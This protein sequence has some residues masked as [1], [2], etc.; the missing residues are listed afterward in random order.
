VIVRHIGPPLARTGGPSGYLLELRNA[1]TAS[2]HVS[3]HEI[4]FPPRAA[5]PH[6][7]EAWAWKA[8]FRRLRRAVFGQ[9]KFYRPSIEDITRPDGAL[10]R[11]IEHSIRATTESC[12]TSWTE[13]DDSAA[14]VLIVHD[15]FA[16]EEA[17]LRR[18]SQE[19]WLMIHCPMPT[20][21]YWAWSWGVPEATWQELVGIP[22]V[23]TWIAR[24]LD[25][26]NE[27]DRVILPCEEALEE[28]A[29]VD[30]SF[31]DVDTPMD[32]VL[33]GSS[34]VH[35]AAPTRP[36][37]GEST[38]LFLG[39]AQPYRGL[40][41]LV[42]ALDHLPGSSPGKILVAGPEKFAVHSHPRI[43]RL[44]RVKD[45]PRLLAS[46]DFIVNVNRFS[47]FDLSN[48]EA[49]AAG[50]PLLLHAV[51]GNKALARLG[52]GC[53]LVYDLTASGLAEALEG[54]FLASPEELETLGRESRTCYERH[55]TAEMMWQ[56]HL[57]LYDEAEKRLGIAETR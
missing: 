33:S 28:L 4:S 29:R 31:A 18:R 11:L 12:Q 55:L 50:K 19:I 10:A 49:V 48:I 22:D 34:V 51:G 20:A 40:D 57:S 30:A 25:V 53:R 26:W 24:E 7:R 16:V 45:V 35:V 43:R 5:A 21:L 14:D 9:P 3:G 15:V 32:Y 2:A 27:V 8:P 13:V 39:N 54:M 56:R 46:V 44:G 37:K 52:A 41:C 6:R 38:G 17:V 23:K 1:A 42:E 47:L 36:R